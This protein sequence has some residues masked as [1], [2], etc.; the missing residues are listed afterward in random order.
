M[1][2]DAN[3]VRANEAEPAVADAAEPASAIDPFAVDLFAGSKGGA[4]AA[5]APA[6]GDATA[7][8][9][10]SRRAP[11]WNSALPKV[12]RDEARLSAMLAAVPASL[13]TSAS[14]AL[15]RVAARLTHTDAAGVGFDVLETREEDLSSFVSRAESPRAFVRVR[16]EPRGARAGLVIEAA[17]ASALIDRMLGGDGATGKDVPRALS[18]AERAVLEFF[19]AQLLNALNEEA[20]EPLFRLEA[21][22]DEAAAFGEG[23]RGIVTAVRARVGSAAGVVRI[24]YDAAA[25]A[26]LD[27]SRSPLL[28]RPRDEGRGRLARY[29]DFCAGARISLL[30]GET[31][32][33][34]ADLAG[35]EA[36]DVVVV[37]RVFGN[38]GNWGE[39]SGGGEAATGAGLRARVGAGDNVLLSGALASPAGEGEAG[40]GGRPGALRLMVEEVSASEARGVEGAGRLR[41][42][43]ESELGEGA[44]AE[45]GLLDNL[46]LT[47]RVELPARR[48]SLEELTRLRA[49]QILELD[50]RATDPVELV[51]DGRRVATGELVDIEGRLGVRVTRLAG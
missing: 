3:T 37:E 49:G 14:A 29:S 6:N 24:V 21:S 10:E 40:G 15:A 20:G 30:V 47:V 44:G 12:S 18:T 19:C 9:G 51:A 17:F 5:G 34:P 25:L 45:A 8:A 42:E 23:G 4:D 26:A 35:L 32:V 38:W 50:C 33:A 11:S 39:W 22:A 27:E 2:T 46:L 36:G 7:P 16:I 1:K 13:S 43:D 31:E 28:A 41:M 48:I